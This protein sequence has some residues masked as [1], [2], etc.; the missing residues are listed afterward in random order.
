MNFV[1]IKLVFEFC[2]F[3]NIFE[4]L[5]TEKKVNISKKGS[6]WNEDNFTWTIWLYLINRFAIL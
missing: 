2:D 1:P 4:L 3:K 5:I 6:D